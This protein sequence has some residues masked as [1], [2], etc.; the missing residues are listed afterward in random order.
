M[1]AVHA[2]RGSG[3]MTCRG[4]GLVVDEGPC[5]AHDGD[6]SNATIEGFLREGSS[7]RIRKRVRGV[8]PD[9]LFRA[10]GGPMPDLPRGTVTF[11]FTDVE[12]STRLWQEHSDAMPA[13]MVRHDAV[14]REVVEGHGGVVFKTMG[15]AVCAAFPTAPGALE[16]ALGAQRALAT[17][18]WGETGPLRVRMALHTGQAEPHDGVTGACRSTACRGCWGRRTTARCCSPCRWRNWC[19]TRCRPVRP[20]EIWANCNPRTSTGRSAPSSFSTPTCRRRSPRYGPQ[21]PHLPICRRPR[22][23]FWVARRW[24]VRPRRSCATPRCVC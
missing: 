15:D 17:Q 13:A 8:S 11:L 20:S 10:A 7:R 6:A 2:G 21:P 4:A 22:H 1:V 23:P 14:V 9:R 12:G 24:S 19:A 3:G 5:Q 16:A 18:E